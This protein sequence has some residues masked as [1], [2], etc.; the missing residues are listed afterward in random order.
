[1]TGTI[2][3]TN[4]LGEIPT[5]PT[6]VLTVTKTVDWNGATP[7]AGQ[8]FAYSIDGG[9]GF[10]TI[11]DT[12]TDNGIMTYSVP[13]GV[14][15]VTETSPGTGW[16][17]TY[18]VSSTVSSTSGVVDLSA[19]AIAPVSPAAID[20]T[21]YR[22]LNSNGVFDS[23][24][25]PN[26]TGLAGVTI[27]AYG[28]DGNACGNT[29][30]RD[31]NGNPNA[32][33]LGTYS[34]TP[35]CDGPW[36]I[37]F[38]NLPDHYEPSIL[39]SDSDSSVRFVTTSGASTIDFAANKPCDYCQDNPD[40]ATSLFLNGDPMVAGAPAS[41]RSLLTFPYNSSGNGTSG[42]NAPTTLAPASETGVVWGL[43]Y[44][45]NTDSLYS[46]ALVKRH[47]GLYESPVGT[48]RPGMIFK[49]DIAGASTTEFVDL[50]TLGVSVGS[51]QPNTDRGLDGTFGPS[52]DADIFDKV[53]KVG[54]GDIDI[55][56]DEKTLWAM[57]L[58]DRTLYSVDIDNPTSATGYPVPNPSCNTFTPPHHPRE[59]W[60]R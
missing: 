25:A 16:V 54:L 36:C 38:T 6:G 42:A 2:T 57:S 4:Y 12:I 18:T 3:V 8:Q 34:L 58:N 53:G 60:C 47:T 19:E 13:S 26:E 31:G 51:V 23:S 50:A 39:G 48:P 43:A 11:N 44:A 59:R 46:S 45:R 29:T 32:G 56:G 24:A 40:V 52:T 33:V 49:T 7:D 20:G 21:V 17:T 9:S 35:S 55:S 5:P 1:M 30:S 37:E 22:D 27:T 41:A 10:T 15:T 28:P 14:Y